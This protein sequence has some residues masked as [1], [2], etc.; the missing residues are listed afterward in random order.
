MLCQIGTEICKDLEGTWIVDPIMSRCV[1]FWQGFAL[2]VSDSLSSI[3][4]TNIRVVT[5]MLLVWKISKS[6][7]VPIVL[8][9]SR[10]DHQPIAKLIPG[11][12]TTDY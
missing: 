4:S 11:H 2:Y 6:A 7:A 1:G 9:E 3:F 5:L 8:V 10:E 12:K